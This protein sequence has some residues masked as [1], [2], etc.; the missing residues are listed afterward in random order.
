[1]KRKGSKRSSKLEDDNVQTEDE[2][3]EKRGRK[4]SRASEPHHSDDESLSPS[5]SNGSPDK[6]GRRSGR[7][8]LPKKTHDEDEAQSSDDEVLATKV[9]PNGD[10][11]EKKKKEKKKKSKGKPSKKKQA[12][13]TEESG[14]SSDDDEVL[15]TK[16]SQNGDTPDKKKSKVKKSKSK[17]TKGKQAK[18]AEDE[19]STAEKDPLADDDEEGG[20][21]SEYEVEKIIDKKI[22]KG[23]TSYLIR[24]KGYG[25]DSDTWEPEN[26]LDCAELIEDFKK[27]Q[28]SKSKKDDKAGKKKKPS[29]KDDEPEE[30]WDENEDFEVD[31]ILD[32]YFHKNGKKDFLV[33]WKGYGSS[34]NSW[35]P[36]DNMDCKDLIAKY[37]EKV[38][39]ARQFE[40][41]ETR[42]RENPKK[43]ARLTIEMH[44][45]ERKLSRRHRGQ[46]GRRHYF[47]AE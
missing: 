32:V 31:R 9:S 37:M 42:L 29:K 17:P 15:A 39:K 5:T 45:S 7:Q 26:T 16:V 27:K 2:P 28:K 43:V 13:V 34:A 24:W 47:D 30:S 11:S 23:V 19:E 3:Q 46:G 44:S 40:S 35:E 41:K 21:D 14:E 12:E 1:M 18:E 6:K 36:E 25:P 10:A 8:S 33:S 20:D 22:T 38:D 4:K